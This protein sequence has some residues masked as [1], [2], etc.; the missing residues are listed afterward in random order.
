MYRTPRK[1]PAAR[2][3]LES[4]DSEDSGPGDGEF[5]CG[6][7]CLHKVIRCTKIPASFSLPIRHHEYSGEGNPDDWLKGHLDA[8]LRKGGTTITAL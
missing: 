1:A 3:N 4:S 5:V 7:N 8:I 6:A 2:I